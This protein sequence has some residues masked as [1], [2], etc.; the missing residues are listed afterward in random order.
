MNS[1]SVLAV[2]DNKDAAYTFCLMLSAWGHRPL[3][4]HDADAAWQA[5]LSE[6]PDVVLLD[7]GLPGVDGWELA[8]RLRAH[9]DLKD[10]VLLA[11]TGHGGPADRARS[12]EVGI[13]QHLLKPV[14][15][16]L[17]QKLLAGYGP[18]VP[19]PA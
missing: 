11:V 2:D 14:E 16:E 10:V 9:P 19:T 3:M 1:L 5:A 13:D 7:L 6:R 12:H 8:R 18:R 4:A 15:P 17:L